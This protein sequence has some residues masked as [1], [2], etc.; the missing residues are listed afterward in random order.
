MEIILMVQL[1]APVTLHKTDSFAKD[2]TFVHYSLPSSENR[3]PLKTC[4]IS[5]W[6]TRFFKR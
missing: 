6:K 3:E 4:S 5:S 1:E 2:S